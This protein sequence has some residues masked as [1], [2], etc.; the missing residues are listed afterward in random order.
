ME[1]VLTLSDEKKYAFYESKSPAAYQRRCIDGSIVG[2]VKC[3]GYC[4]Y[5]EHPGFLTEEQRKT[6]NCVGKGCNYYLQKP[7][8]EKDEKAKDLSRE[9]L[10]FAK[11][12]LSI[13]SG[14]LPLR[15]E[16][17]KQYGV[18]QIDYIAITNDCCF[19]NLLSAI[20]QKFH[21]EAEFIR[22]NYDFDRCVALFC[23]R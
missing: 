11:S 8:R 6:H 14:S 3:V 18:Y 2:C 12:H 22:L 9:I 20:R 19:E 23:A 16:L 7:R 21:V 5:R 17:S 1:S 13:D 10:A 4:Q 15:V